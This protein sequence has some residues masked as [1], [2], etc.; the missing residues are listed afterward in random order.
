VRWRLEMLHL[1]GEDPLKRCAVCAVL[2]R[3][4]MVWVLLGVGYC[5]ADPLRCRGITHLQ[6][7]DACRGWS[8]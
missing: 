6:D 4:A 3:L 7:A 1:G 2:G 5:R 8:R